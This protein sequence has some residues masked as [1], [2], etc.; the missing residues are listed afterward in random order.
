MPLT[1]QFFL[2]R[3]STK[4]GQSLFPVAILFLHCSFLLIFAGIVSNDVSEVSKHVGSLP[5]L[6]IRTLTDVEG[7][8]EIIAIP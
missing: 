2:R 4:N 8:V 3:A 5:F 7:E 6:E 1:S